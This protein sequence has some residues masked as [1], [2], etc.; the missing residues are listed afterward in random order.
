[1]EPE[2]S[3]AGSPM[4]AAMGLKK[5]GLPSYLLNG[6]VENLSHKGLK[7][8]KRSLASDSGFLHDDD[9]GSG[10]DEVRPFS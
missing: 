9:Y 2:S 8:S 10:T 1:M 7:P 3:S 4:T 5:S 6:S